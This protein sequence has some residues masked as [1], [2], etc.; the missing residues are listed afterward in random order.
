MNSGPATHKIKTFKVKEAISGYWSAVAEDGTQISTSF[1]EDERPDLAIELTKGD[2]VEIQY[3]DTDPKL[4]TNDV[5]YPTIYIE[6]V[7][8]Q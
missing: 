7:T 3:I 5:I 1:D 8:K 6:S 4:W 2:M